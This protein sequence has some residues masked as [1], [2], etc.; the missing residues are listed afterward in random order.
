MMRDR[1]IHPPSEDLFAYRDGELSPERRALIEAHVLGCSTCRSFIDQV[2]SLEA[3]LRQSPDRA[4]A[5]YLE[6]LH[7]AVRARIVAAG[8]PSAAEELMEEAARPGMGR[9]RRATARPGARERR[10]DVEGV[11]GENVRVKEAPRLPWAAVM[12]TASAAAAVLVVAIILMRQGFDHR[13]PLPAAHAPERSSKMKQ[14]PLTGGKHDRDLKTANR[15]KSAEQER[16]ALLAKEKS[17]GTLE[18]DRRRAAASN[19]TEAKAGESTTGNVATVGEGARTDQVGAKKAEPLADR[20]Q[21]ST[22]SG[23]ETRG[24]A[25]DSATEPEATAAA[26][27][28]RRSIAPSEL[29]PAPGPSAYGALVNRLGLPPVWDASRVTPE[30]LERAEPELRALYVSGNAGADSGR[31]RLYLAEAVR[32]RYTPGDSARYDEI[33][34]HYKRAVSL[35]KGDPKTARIA[36]ERLQTLEK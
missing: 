16:E 11:A 20:V 22:S 12:S 18:S 28:P 27:E 3:E 29:P 8:P 19:R 25:S 13:A 1:P 26:P 5:E 15:K 10:G 2:S 31:I 4:P 17:Q 36:A 14:A 32:A 23:E 9:D 33:E 34:R 21:S 30:A 24:R 6:H 7:E 35:S